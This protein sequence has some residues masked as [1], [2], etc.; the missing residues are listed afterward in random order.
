MP[1]VRV[2]RCAKISA[3]YFVVCKS[4]VLYNRSLAL[5]TWHNIIEGI[6]NILRCVS[7]L[8]SLDL[9]NLILSSSRMIPLCGFRHNDVN[10]TISALIYYCVPF[11]KNFSRHGMRTMMSVCSYCRLIGESLAGLF[12]ASQL[13]IVTKTRTS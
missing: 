9:L 10:S 3:G 13:T 2:C 1:G 5:N 7:A 8:R 12:A 11:S 6:A 4:E